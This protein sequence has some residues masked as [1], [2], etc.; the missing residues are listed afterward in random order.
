MKEL[1][2][3]ENNLKHKKLISLLADHYTEYNARLFLKVVM[4]GLEHTPEVKTDFRTMDVQRAFF[5]LGNEL[6]IDFLEDAFHGDNA[7]K[8]REL[9]EKGNKYAQQRLVAGIVYGY[10]PFKK[11]LDELKEL[12]LKGNAVARYFVWDKSEKWKDD[13]YS[14]D[15]SSLNQ[16][17]EKEWMEAYEEAVKQLEGEEND[18]ITEG[19]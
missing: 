2:M 11:N 19:Q 5:N 14:L 1:I 13:I 12:V 16:W 15:F 4:N 3:T 9:S 7:K 18:S 6:E 10:R 8:I 17:S